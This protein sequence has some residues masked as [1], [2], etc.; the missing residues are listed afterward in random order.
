MV[1]SGFENTTLHSDT[2]VGRYLLEVGNA[3]GLVLCLI[4]HDPGQTER[5]RKGRL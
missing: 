1:K 5:E 2:H 4:V 3:G